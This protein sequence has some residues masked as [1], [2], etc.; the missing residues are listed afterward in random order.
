MWD[1]GAGLGDILADLGHHMANLRYETGV[2]ILQWLRRQ[3]VWGQP[4]VL[5]NLR[6]GVQLCNSA[7]LPVCCQV[8]VLAPACLGLD[9]A[10]LWLSGT[11][12][13]VMGIPV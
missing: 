7:V 5:G 11:P 6:V 4:G 10:E 13:L 8:Q 2:S 9:T 1:L 12:G 3:L